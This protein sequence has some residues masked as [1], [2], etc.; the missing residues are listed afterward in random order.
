M[1]LQRGD[2]AAT[3]FYGDSSK[4]KKMIEVGNCSMWSE[5]PDVSLELIL[6]QVGVIE[7]LLCACVCKS[8][9]SVVIAIKQEFMAAQGPLVFL[10]TTSPRKYCYFYNVFDKRLYRTSLPHFPGNKCL[11]FTCGYLVIRDEA[12]PQKNANIWLVNPFTRHELKFP[13]PPKRYRH[14]ILVSLAKSDSEYVVIAFTRSR[15]LLQFCRSGVG[16]WTVLDYGE[17]PWMIIDVVFFKGKIYFLT[18]HCK[19]GTLNLNSDPMTTFLN[20]KN[21]PASRDYDLHLVASREELYIAR[22]HAAAGFIKM[23]RLDF[24]KMEWE[25]VNLKGQILF[26][27]DM[28]SCAL[29]FPTPSMACFDKPL[30][31]VFHLGHGHVLGGYTTRY[32]AGRLKEQLLATQM[33]VNG[34]PQIFLSPPLWY[35]PHLSCT[36]DSVD[37]D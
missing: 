3:D 10:M 18:D 26:L 1:A 28:K 16:K 2:D 37:E 22:F 9:R 11:G 27:S 24:E 5:L 36:V 8:W 19:I 31:Q 33:D 20:A 25:K 17:H 13:M 15:P 21:A 32:V 4:R 7:F 30:N 23:H 14:V 6:R 29:S 12:L 35:F 34:K